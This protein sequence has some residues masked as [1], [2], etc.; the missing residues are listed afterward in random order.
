[1]VYDRWH[2]TVEVIEIMKNTPLANSKK[3]WKA[4]IPCRTWI[5]CARLRDEIE[6]SL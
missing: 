6:K 3:K 4:L 2:K 1:M 5:Y